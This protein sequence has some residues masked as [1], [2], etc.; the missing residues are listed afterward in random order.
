MTSVTERV[1]D[2]PN[3]ES[4]FYVGPAFMLKE[5]SLPQMPYTALLQKWDAYIVHVLEALAAL[6]KAGLVHGA[7]D[8]HGLR[9]SKEGRVKLAGIRGEMLLPE[10]LDATRILPPEILLAAA[11]R[12]GISFSTAY[13]ALEGDNYAMDFHPS[14]L[15]G[16]HYTRPVLEHVWKTDSVGDAGQ[17]A[18]VWM[19]GQALFS[20]YWDM[21]AA[22]PQSA[23]SE[24]YK[25]YHDRFMAL[26]GRMLAVHPMDRPTAEEAM[27]YWNPRLRVDSTVSVS[28]DDETDVPADVSAA[29]SPSVTAAPQRK[30][31][32]ALTGWRGRAVRNKTRRSPHS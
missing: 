16:V 22:V 18:D 25:Q 23:N 9:L 10:H 13:N 27:G 11:K 2:I 32:L 20:L 15:E 17:K 14:V 3:T 7:L 24:F 29:A 28:D 26:M 19:A 6:H 31:R 5:K 4:Y 21:L 12:D 30:P 1:L 8:A